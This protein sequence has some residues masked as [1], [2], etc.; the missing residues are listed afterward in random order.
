MSQP[1]VAIIHLHVMVHEV[2]P[3][4]EVSGELVPGRELV[5]NGIG[6]RSI[7]K[8]DGNTKQECLDKVSEAI[9]NLRSVN[10]SGRRE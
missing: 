4:G 8:I 10:E 1:H 7:H 6:V 9:Q 2:L 5:E 3:T